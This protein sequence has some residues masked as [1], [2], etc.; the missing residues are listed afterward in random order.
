MSIE[1]ESTDILHS[2]ATWRLEP[3]FQDASQPATRGATVSRS[4]CLHSESRKFE[5]SKTR[6]EGRKSKIE[7]FAYSRLALGF[8]WY[9]T[10][11]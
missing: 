6:V 11:L 1:I 4:I 5:T 10:C 9:S 2:V 3:E 7:D 8:P